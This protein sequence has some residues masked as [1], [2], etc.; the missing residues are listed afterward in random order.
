[1]GCKVGP[2]VKLLGLDPIQALTFSFP[3][4]DAFDRRSWARC[5]RDYKLDYGDSVCGQ[6]FTFRRRDAPY[7][8]SHK[9]C[10]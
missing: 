7:L 2:A 6:R 1:V 3:K 5:P 9:G 4:I 10:H 8:V